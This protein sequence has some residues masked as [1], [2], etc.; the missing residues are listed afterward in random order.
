MNGHNST[1]RIK[2]NGLE[3]LMTVGFRYVTIHWNEKQRL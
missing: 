1:Y 3:L 2:K